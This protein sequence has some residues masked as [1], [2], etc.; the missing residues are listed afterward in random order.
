MRRSSTAGGATSTS[1]TG[2]GRWEPVHRGGAPAQ[3]PQAARHASDV[4]RPG[5]ARGHRDGPGRV[6]ARPAIPVEPFIADVIE[7][8]RG[9]WRYRGRSYR[10]SPKSL[11]LFEHEYAGGA[12][13]RGLAGPQPERGQLS[14]QLLPPAPPGRDPAAPS[15][16]TGPSSTG[17][18]F[19]SRARWSGWRPI[20]LLDARPLGLVDW[21]TGPPS[22]ES[23][24][25][26]LG[27]YAFYAHEALGVAPARVD[28]YEV[29]LREPQVTPLTWTNARLEAI[30]E[31][32]R[33]FV[34]LDEALPGR[35]LRQRGDDRGLRAGRGLRLCRWCNFARCAPEPQGI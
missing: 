34:P 11:A 9:E 22:R 35:S 3:R 20:W 1:T 12:Q 21:K 4:G 7:R 6:P 29:N 30:K 32:L 19:E 13:A 24:A 5:G 18:S 10:E 31:R 27:C 17:P 16:R 8:M 23:T 26:Q 2:P 28:L 15:A 14:A 33:L 25:F